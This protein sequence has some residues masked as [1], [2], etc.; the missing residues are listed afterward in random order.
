MNA[1]EE[2][3]LPPGSDAQVYSS[4]IVGMISAIVMNPFEVIKCHRQAHIP[5]EWNPRLVFRGIVP[6]IMREGIGFSSYFGSYLWLYRRSYIE[7]AH[8]SRF[9]C[10]AVAGAVS[11]ICAFPL[12]IWKTRSQV[13]P[14]SSYR[15]FPWLG[16]RIALVRSVLVN[17]MLFV[18][19]GKD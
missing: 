8:E 2:T 5:F 9:V 13:I 10:G 14:I 7:P 12:D 19:I 17:G 16:L 18:A 4:S 1:V 11:T 6:H 15:F 3:L